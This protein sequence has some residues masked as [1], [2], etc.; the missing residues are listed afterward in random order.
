MWHHILITE[1]MYELYLNL[2]SIIYQW[3]ILDNIL[4]IGHDH[5]SR[6]VRGK[7]EFFLAIFLLKK[8]MR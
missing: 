8:R 4:T 3:L 1:I 7:A 2:I 5:Q 6:A